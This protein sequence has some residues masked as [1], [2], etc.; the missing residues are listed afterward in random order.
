MIHPN[1]EQG[2]AEWHEFRK[3]KIGGS[4]APIICG[5]SPW[6][7]NLTLWL[8]KLGKIE[9]PNLKDNYAVQRGVR[10]EPVVRGMVCLELDIDFEPA[11]I[12]HD[13]F[14]YLSASLDGW[15]EEKKALIEIKVGNK[16]DHDALKKENPKSIPK[17]YYAQVQHQI[18]VTGASLAYYCSYYLAK[19]ADDLSG[20]LKIVEVTKDDDFINRYLPVAH[21]FH[22]C[23]NEDRPPE[24]VK[25]NA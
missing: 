18:F 6:K 22:K 23:M 13:E 10:L 17:K 9:Q 24:M 16:K 11:V 7:S 25:L 14:P 2:S 8:E 1:Y 21:E 19:G 20:E 12:T 15:N 3:G 5:V 4:D